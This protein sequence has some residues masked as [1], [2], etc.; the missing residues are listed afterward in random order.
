M[1][2]EQ[3]MTNEVETCRPEDGLHRAVQIMWERD[4]GFVPVVE[5]DEGRRLVGVVTDRD[6]CMALYLRGKALA[7]LRVAD[8]MSKLLRTCRPADAIW[9][10]ES[11]MREA[12][13]HRLPIVDEAGRLVGVLSL[14]D[15]ACVA[16]REIGPRHGWISSAEV[17]ETL[18]Q[19][20]QPRA[21]PTS[22]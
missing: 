22:V 9:A 2:V 14:S 13:V 11:A 10:A 19:I 7:E 15:I 4:C 8:V 17:G 1:K 20:H 3:L 16:G 6:A 21:N 12:Q 5:D 18:A